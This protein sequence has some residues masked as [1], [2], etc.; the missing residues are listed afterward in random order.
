MSEK[1]ISLAFEEAPI[2]ALQLLQI[3]VIIFSGGNKT[4]TTFFYDFHTPAPN[5]CAT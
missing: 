3:F 1:S 4:K 2:R 5:K